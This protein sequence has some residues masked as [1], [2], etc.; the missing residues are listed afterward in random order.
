MV[1]TKK[2][3]FGLKEFSKILL[4]LSAEEIKTATENGDFIEVK[5]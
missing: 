1:P 5:S 4:E 3:L 2:E